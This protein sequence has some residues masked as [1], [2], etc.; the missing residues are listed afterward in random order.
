MINLDILSERKEIIQDV[1]DRLLNN[2]DYKNELIMFNINHPLNVQFK[3]GLRTVQ[4][5]EGVQ[6]TIYN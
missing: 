1:I 5:T 6:K 4:K 2:P 3:K